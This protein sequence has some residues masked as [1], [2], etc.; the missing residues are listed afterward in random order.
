MRAVWIMAGAINHRV[1]CDMRAFQVRQERLSQNRLSW[2]RACHLRQEQCPFIELTLNPFSGRAL[3]EQKAS[4]KGACAA[5]HIGCENC[6]SIQQNTLSGVRAVTCN[7]TATAL[8]VIGGW[9]S[10][11]NLLG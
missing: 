10:L 7:L 1:V 9:L 2:M 4:G 5:S 8:A 11:G 3:R 6:M